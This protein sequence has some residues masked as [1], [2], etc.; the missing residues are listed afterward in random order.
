MSAF[1]GEGLGDGATDTTSG[2]GHQRGTTRQTVGHGCTPLLDSSV[3]SATF[4]LD[5]QVHFVYA[6][7]VARD[8]LTTKGVATRQRI[9][10]G[11]AAL[12]R[13]QGVEHVGLD[14]IRS[15][16]A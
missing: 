15:V 6:R 10:A 4:L 8:Q 16:T 3:H 5:R 14:D 2:P 1:G 13:A 7:R 11:A 12:I 9:V